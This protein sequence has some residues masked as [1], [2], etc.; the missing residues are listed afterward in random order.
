MRG[1]LESSQDQIINNFCLDDVVPP[2]HLDRQ[3]ATHIL[4]LFSVN[5]V[6]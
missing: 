3:T 5:K 6:E 2:D 1:R 4:V